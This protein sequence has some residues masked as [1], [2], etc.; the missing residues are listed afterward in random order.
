MEKFARCQRH[1]L[2]TNHKVSILSL[3]PSKVASRNVSS[4]YWNVQALFFVEGNLA[5]KI[6]MEFSWSVFHDLNWLPYTWDIR[7]VHTID[8]HEYVDREKKLDIAVVH[9]KVAVPVA[10]GRFTLAY[11]VSSYRYYRRST[12][13]AAPSPHSPAACFALSVLDNIYGGHL[14]DD[15]EVDVNDG[16]AFTFSHWKELRSKINHC[17]HLLWSELSYRFLA[18]STVYWTMSLSV[19]ARVDRYLLLRRVIFLTWF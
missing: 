8:A 18:S 3:V 11:T 6:T 5:T 1:Q 10:Y 13:S 9:E 4:I 16:A 15:S 2:R 14:H 7:K 19:G 17:F 12:E